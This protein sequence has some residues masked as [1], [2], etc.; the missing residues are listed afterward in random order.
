MSEL[1]SLFG[2][3]SEGKKQ[4][5]VE[6]A[7]RIR[8]EE[9]INEFNSVIKDIANTNNILYVDVTEISRR[10]LTEKDL[11]ANDSLHPSGKM[12]RE[13]AEKIYNLWIE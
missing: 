5:E 4:A 7:E 11:I 3:I 8:I 1:A 6:K 12:Y 10:A 13:W 9:E 2:I